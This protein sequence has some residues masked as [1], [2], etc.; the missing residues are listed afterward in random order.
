MAVFCSCCGPCR[1]F[2]PDPIC[3]DLFKTSSKFAAVHIPCG[4]IGALQAGAHVCIHL[5]RFMHSM[6]SV[7]SII[8]VHT[9]QIQAPSAQVC[10][11]CPGTQ[12]KPSVEQ[13]PALRNCDTVVT[14]KDHTRN[15]RDNNA[16]TEM[17]PSSNASGQLQGGMFEGPYR[18]SRQVTGSVRILLYQSVLMFILRY[19]MQQ[20]IPAGGGVLQCQVSLP[21][22]GPTCNGKRSQTL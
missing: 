14:V 10:W 3:L 16:T 15:G 12:S 2:L 19:T 22:V 9:S 8:N 5:A 13:G 1:V 21:S 4:V 18:R 11:G 7:G 17:P 20:H 6:C